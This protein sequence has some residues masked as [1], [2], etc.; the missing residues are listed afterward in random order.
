MDILFSANNFEEVIRLPVIP[1]SLEINEPWNNEE[2]ETI[3][4]GTLRLIGLRGLRTL[5]IESFFPLKEYP[6]AKDH[7][8]GWEYVQFFRKWRDKRVPIRIIITLD[9]GSEMLNM[10]VVVDDFT[11]GLDN[12]GDIPYSLSLTEFVFVKVT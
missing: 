1:S 12:A 7:R 9:D 11:Y 8:N 2:F 10:P 6:F 4:Q 3:G 5:S